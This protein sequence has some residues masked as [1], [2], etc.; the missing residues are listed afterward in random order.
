MEKQFPSHELRNQTL[1]FILNKDLIRACLEPSTWGWKHGVI[2]A[3]CKIP[4]PPFS[5]SKLD[6]LIGV[7]KTYQGQR[8]EMKIR[9]TELIAKVVKGIVN[10]CVLPF[11][12][13]HALSRPGVPVVQQVLSKSGFKHCSGATL[14]KCMQLGEPEETHIHPFSA[15]FA[16]PQNPGSHFEELQSTQQGFHSEL[17]SPVGFHP[18]EQHCCCMLSMQ[19]S[20]IL[21]SAQAPLPALMM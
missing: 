9:R 12:Y 10:R 16:V 8:V 6:I 21:K 13:L 5:C 15:L 19:F 7:R 2:H 1:G 11:A 20:V 4:L 18:A 3:G 14:L 17:G